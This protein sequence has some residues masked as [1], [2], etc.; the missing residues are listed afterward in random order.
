MLLTVKKLFFSDVIL[1]FPCILVIK[2]LFLIRA[3]G[4]GAS[5]ELVR[6]QSRKFAYK[7]FSHDKCVINHVFHRL[8]LVITMLL[9]VI[10][11]TQKGLTFCLSDLSGIMVSSISSKLDFFT[12]HAPLSSRSSNSQPSVEYSSICTMLLIKRKGNK[13]SGYKM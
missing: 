5:C 1:V 8:Y 9:L 11:V 6:S 10:G 2:P 12:Y 3:F 4:W 13:D 7:F